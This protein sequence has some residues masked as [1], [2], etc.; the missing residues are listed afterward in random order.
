MVAIAQLYQ[1]LPDSFVGSAL[2]VIAS[3]LSIVASV[4]T[5]LTLVATLL[6]LRIM[7]RDERSRRDQKVS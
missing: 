7:M 5:L 1:H 3:I 2:P 4:A 6:M